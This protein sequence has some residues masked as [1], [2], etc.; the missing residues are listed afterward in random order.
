MPLQKVAQT[1]LVAEAPPGGNLVA[2]WIDFCTVQSC[3]IEW[4]SPILN[5][6]SRPV[7]FVCTVI[8][9]ESKDVRHKLKLLLLSHR[10]CTVFKLHSS[11]KF[12]CELPISV[13][14]LRDVLLYLIWS[15]LRHHLFVETALAVFKSITRWHNLLFWGHKSGVLAQR[16]AVYWLQWVHLS[17]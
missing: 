2:R 4:A 10:C 6:G 3:M 11:G 16:P 15:G 7:C 1:R 14:F 5:L 13:F 8:L 17:G 9:Y 12:F